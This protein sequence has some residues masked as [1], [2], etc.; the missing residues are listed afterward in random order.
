LA[1]LVL[2]VQQPVLDRG[3]RRVRGPTTGPLTPVAC[4][5]LDLEL[6]D[7]ERSSLGAMIGRR[8]CGF[9]EDV[10]PP[11]CPCI[12]RVVVRDIS[13]RGFPTSQIERANHAA[14]MSND[15]DL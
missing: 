9:L 15:D 1:H 3:G 5:P 13:S 2:Q 7:E 6:T 11:L 4:W 12:T 14:H 8:G 10:S